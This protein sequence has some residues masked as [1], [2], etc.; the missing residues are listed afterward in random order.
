[1][2]I[3]P[4]RLINGHV[5]FSDRFIQP[6]YSADLTDL[7]GSL[8]H[9]SSQA[10]SGL[11]DL[12][13][14][15]R[16]EG[17]ASLEITGKLNPLVKP[18][19]LA[20]NGR[21]RDLELSPLSSYAIKYA[22][23]GIERG[24]LSVDVNYTVAPNG[25]LQASNKIVL[26]Q[27]VFGDEVPGVSH[28][29]VKLAVALLADRNGVIDLDLPVS[30]SLNDPQFRIWP[31]VWKIVGNLIAKALTSPFHL[32]S[33]LFNGGDAAD[34][35]KNIAFDAGT[36]RISPSSLPSLDQIGKA[37]LDKPALRLTVVGTASLEREVDAIKR[38]RLA[39]QLMGEKRRV[40]AGAAKD[41]TSVSVVSAEEAPVL[42]KEVYRRSNL[43]KPRNTVGIAKEQSTEEMEALLLQAI[44]VDEDAVRALAL[45][46]S[47]A[48][49][50][51]LTAHKVPSDQLFMGEVEIAPAGADWQPRAEL[52]IEHH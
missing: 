26:N 23:Y 14:R 11:A 51:Y 43:K 18:L 52:S 22:G 29:P 36:A 38:D 49:R 5:A 19:E 48:V 27:L 32:I 35:L 10:G 41:V 2:D 39:S 45:N 6:H 1:M 16:A 4:I 37:M 9:F 13:L 20:I 44:N 25:Q 15:G 8:S 46:R 33:G 24:K 50:E 47:L 34:E 21:V 12:E 31:I 7:S 30:G 28:L 40:A 17:T 3:G 42:L